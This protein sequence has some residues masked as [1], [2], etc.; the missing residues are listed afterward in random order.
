MTKK[1]RANLDSLVLLT[2]IIV[3]INLLGF[4]FIKI[5]DV[6]KYE[7]YQKSQI[8]NVSKTDQECIITGCN[9]EICASEETA[10]IC[11]YN[12]KFECYESAV[13]EVQADDV[14]GWTQ[15]DALLSCL[16]VV[17]EKN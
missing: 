9:G 16:S 4:V 2:I 12:P 10:S 5:I 14:C 7:A 8:Q 3:F 11:I 6:I 17:S 13:C 15:T 1:L